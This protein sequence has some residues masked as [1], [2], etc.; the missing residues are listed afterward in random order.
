MNMDAD[1]DL[2]IKTAARD[3]LLRLSLQE[4]TAADLARFE[5]WRA[6][7]PRHAAM[8]GRFESIWEGV[9]QLEELEPL[10]AA[11]APAP[12]WSQRV[13][14][15]L[16][17]YSL[18]HAM[19]FAVAAALALFG[20][21]FLLKPVHHETGL[22]EIRQIQLADGSEVTLG[23]RSALDV[24]FS[25]GE[26]HVALTSGEAFFAVAKNPARPFVVAV[27]DKQV[28]V[29]GTQFEVRQ[30]ATDVRVSVV[31]GVVKVTDDDGPHERTLLAGQ[32]VVAAFGG[33]IPE[34]GSIRSEIAPWRHGRLV[35]VDAMLSDVIADANRYSREP[36]VIT[37]E[38]VG[39]LRVSVTAPTDKI[40][41]MIAALGRSLPIRIERQERGGILIEPAE[42][43]APPRN[44][45]SR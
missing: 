38:Q 24:S 19:S 42:E 36:I 39:D 31:E 44:P 9:A 8:Y 23:A 21:W 26:R 40:N 33:A 6:E 45:P 35:Y 1:H 14:N 34:P 5:A 22:G 11:D 41:E 28:R 10:L 16:R 37:G 43:G 29:V 18:Q 13:T 17:A 2:H 20:V 15:A 25:R 12:R 30:S 32:Q 7:D 27:G 3:W 4:P